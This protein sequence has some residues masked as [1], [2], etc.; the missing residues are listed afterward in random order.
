MSN[1]QPPF[2]PSSLALNALSANLSMVLSQYETATCTASKA[3]AL[4][5]VAETSQKLASAATHPR[6]FHYE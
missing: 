3:A 1:P 4:Q 6:T 2:E 5:S